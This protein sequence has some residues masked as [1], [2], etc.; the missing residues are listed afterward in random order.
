M[1]KWLSYLHDNRCR[2]LAG[3]MDFLRIPSISSISSHSMDMDR[4]AEWVE[5]RL[6]AAGLEK[7]AILPTGGPPIVYGECLQDVNK[8][9]ILIYGHYDV[10]PVEP[11]R[12]WI[13]APFDPIIE[14]ERI[15]GRGTADAK[16]QILIPICAV[17][18]LIKTGTDL[19]VNIKFL[20]EGEE[21]IS[22]PHLLDF[23][24]IHKDLLSCS[25][26]VCIDGQQWS[27]DQPRLIMGFRGSCGCQI[28]VYGP[29]K[30]LHSG[31]FAG[32]IQNPIHALSQIL[33]SLHGAD[34]RIAISGFYDAVRPASEAEREAIAKVP[35]DESQYQNEVGVG[36]IWGEPNFTTLERAWIRP[37]LEVIGIWGGNYQEA[38]KGIIPS[39]AHARIQCRLVP[40]Q[41][42]DTTLEQIKKH[43]MNNSLPGVRVN[44]IR[45]FNQSLPYSIPDHHPALQIAGSVLEEL[46][47]KEPC[48]SRMGGSIPSLN[49][50]YRV[51]G[52]H[53]LV[54]AF[55]LP[56]ENEHSPNEFFRLSS[57]DLGQKAYG[58]LL[59]KME[60]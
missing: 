36:S 59:T 5:K 16:G 53:T 2:F 34:G 29:A 60:G 46:Y 57:F 30:D 19:Q 35:F 20:F 43:I 6:K 42:P 41:D 14:N 7:V 27:E 25:L 21:E 49:L 10:Q 18:A 17:E 3:L 58:M 4:A 47:G 31:N 13:R 52:V 24:S 15:Y 55:G 39:E 12:A 44:V 9:T 11:E 26:V 33:S 32:T 23:L 38:I 40:D 8:P 45:S 54:F 1:E 50:F 37:A 56:D 22:S 28:D 51:L 48:Y